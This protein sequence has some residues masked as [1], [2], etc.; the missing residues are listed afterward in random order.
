VRK[1]YRVAPVD[2]HDGCQY[3]ELPP[4]PAWKLTT[5]NALRGFL[6]LPFLTIAKSVQSFSRSKRPMAIA[7]IHVVPDEGFD[8]WVVRDD[9]GYELGHYPTRESAELVSQAIARKLRGQFVVYPP[10]EQ[11]SRTNSI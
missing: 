11:T 7:A 2:R 1:I 9:S 10:A 6:A 4:A 8:D 3:C 5:I